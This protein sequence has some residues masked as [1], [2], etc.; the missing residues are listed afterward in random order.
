MNLIFR[1]LRLLL[2][3]ALRRTRI[4]LLDEAVLPL[5]AWPTDLD[6]NL[7]LTN[8][9]YLS[10][11][12]LGRIDLLARAGVL[13]PLV[14]RRWQPLVGSVAVRY[15]RPIDPMQR[16]TLKTR[17][18]CWDE[19]WFYIEQR[20]EVNG[21]LATLAYVR[22]LFR[23]PQ[24]NVRPQEVLAAGGQPE[25][26]SPPPPAVV[27]EWQRMEDDINGQIAASRRAA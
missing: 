6:L 24:G 10:M 4:D 8:S 25:R 18:L 14:R 21:R 3:A 9:R 13:G 17:L 22:G 5:R 1:L 7:H 26:A 23:G 11:M 15:H 2:A 19:K 16:F 20:F 27:A 12:D